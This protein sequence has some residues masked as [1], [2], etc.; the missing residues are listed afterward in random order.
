MPKI[1]EPG[2]GAIDLENGDCRFRV[3]AP[4]AERVEVD[5]D[6]R[7]AA[8]EPT[9]N[10]YFEGVV[11]G[12]GPGTLYAYRL[13]GGDARPDPASRFQPG[14]VH[15]PSQVVARRFD[16]TDEGWRGLPLDEHILYELHVGTFTPEGT[17][18]AVIPQLDRLVDLGIT[19]VE[20]MPVA[21]FPGT[22]N[23]GYDGALPFAVQNSYGGPEGLKRLVDACHARGLAVVLDVVYN[24]LG[25]EGN[26]LSEFGPYFTERYKTPWGLAINY[27]GPHS[28]PVRRYFIENALHWIAEYHFD[29]LRLDAVHAIADASER[30]FLQELGTEVK[31]LAEGLGRRVHVFPES[32]INTLFFLRPPERGGCGFD[33]QWTDDFHHCL[34]SLLTGERDGYY[35]DFG[36]LAQMAKAMAGGFVYTGQYSPYR[37]R[38]HGVPADEMEG[39]RHVVAI[40]NHDQT[41]N[42]MNGERIASLVDFESRK[43]AAGAVLLSPFL[44]LLFM[45]EEHGET[46]PFLYFVS[47]SEPGLIESVREGR[48]E[49]FAAFGWPGEPPDPQSEETFE[50]SRPTARN[51]EL[52]AFYKELIG[53][54]KAEP[55]LRNLSKADQEVSLF[56]DLGV[57][58]ARRWSGE[59]EVVIAY[60]FAEEERA[61]PVPDGDWRKLLDSGCAE[62]GGEGLRMGRRSVVMLGR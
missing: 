60:N 6:G 32:D 49:E 57:I 55:A 21:Q 15:G 19:A 30:P 56:E 34:H 39:S 27:D 12:A 9:E 51:E 14:T 13:D 61:V 41:G 58:V 40:Q 45:G 26:Y 46:A 17:F 20:L 31:A 50:R 43:L 54:R 24:H 18:D 2:L 28:D 5:L 52:Y 38:R 29:G 42:R 23:W 36:S 16:W 47:H 4:N 53:C 44:P 37:R 7:R 59:N 3:W 48:R 8:L 10:G 22:R 25:P 62:I 11:E 35:R 33:A 1:W